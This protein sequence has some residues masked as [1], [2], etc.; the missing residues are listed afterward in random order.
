METGQIKPHFSLPSLIALGAAIASFFV[1]ATGGFILAIVAILC[2]LIGIL[3]SFSPS[4][5]GGLISVFSLI[6][7]AIAIVAALG[8][9]IAWAL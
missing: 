9:A 8:K 6:L 5:R 1:G 7:S 2:G 3:L 4:V